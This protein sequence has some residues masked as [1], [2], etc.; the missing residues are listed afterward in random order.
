[1]SYNITFRYIFLT[2]FVLYL[3]LLL[4]PNRSAAFSLRIS[5]IDHIVHS[6]TDYK[7]DTIFMEVN[8][9]K[10]YILAGEKTMYLMNFNSGDKHYRTV[11]VNE[12]GDTQYADSVENYQWRGK[13]VLIK[14]YKLGSRVIVAQSIEKIADQSR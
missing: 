6:E 4:C 13:R 5:D 8:P 10:G 9:I 14:G 2:V 3:G 1:M 11:F 12:R 7:I